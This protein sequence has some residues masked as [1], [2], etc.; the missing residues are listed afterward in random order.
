[1][2]AAD[3]L[4][5]TS[6]HVFRRCC[7]S[8]GC[9]L[10][11][12]VALVTAAAGGT[13]VAARR[14][15]RPPRPRIALSRPT[16]VSSKGVPAF[17]GCGDEPPETPVPATDEAW[18]GA[19]A[20]LTTWASSS[21]NFSSTAMMFSA[22]AQ[23]R[24]APAAAPSVA[25]A[26]SGATCPEVSIWRGFILTAEAAHS[27]SSFRWINK[28]SWASGPFINLTRISLNSPKSMLPSL[29]Q[30]MYSKDRLSVSS[31]TPTMDNSLRAASSSSSSL[32]S[33]PL[34]SA[35][36]CMKSCSMRCFSNFSCS[37]SLVLDTI[38]QITPIRIFR[39][40]SAVMIMN[41]ISAAPCK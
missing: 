41:T 19:A 32:E 8:S 37:P 26:R 22:L 16:S 10:L 2:E 25:L 3:M 40:V 17:G 15:R 23:E 18:V 20:M 31:S 27:L 24:A 36:S 4:C 5:I 34:P 21:F 12:G 28:T 1:M 14:S 9:L 33:L 29:S 6:K 35:S 7:N 30:S 39:R 38:S 13:Q 11:S